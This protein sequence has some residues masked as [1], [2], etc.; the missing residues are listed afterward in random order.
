MIRPNTKRRAILEALAER[1]HSALELAE[2]TDDIPAT[3]ARTMAKLRERGWAI[4]G[5]DK[6]GRGSRASY[7]ITAAGRAVI[8]CAPA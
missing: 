4:N 8:G 1:P 6:A 3:V 5:A 2:I 7:Q